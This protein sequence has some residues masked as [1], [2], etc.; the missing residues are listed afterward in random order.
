MGEGASKRLCLSTCKDDT[1]ADA[2][3]VACESMIQDDA[4]HVPVE[5]L[6]HVL[7]VTIPLCVAYMHT[8]THTYV[9]KTQVGKQVHVGF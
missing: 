5:V 2:A 8:H 6:F 9:K 4:H 7:N 3:G 1:A